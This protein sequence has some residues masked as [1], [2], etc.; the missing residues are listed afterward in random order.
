MRDEDVD[1]PSLDLPWWL[2]ILRKERYSVLFKKGTAPLGLNLFETRCKKGVYVSGFTPQQTPGA[3]LGQGLAQPPQPVTPPLNVIS[4]G[5]VLVSI[6][7][8]DCSQLSLSAV[9][10]LI[11]SSRRRDRFKELLTSASSKDTSGLA[12]K[13]ERK[14]VTFGF[15]RLRTVYSLADVVLDPRKL[16]FLVNFLEE[17]E[18]I[19]SR[20]RSLS[21]DN[22]VP[23]AGIASTL[24]SSTRRISD[25]FG[26]AFRG[27]NTPSPLRP[28]IA[29]S[30]H[31]LPPAPPPPWQSADGTAPIVVA[32]SV[33]YRGS[34]RSSGASS[35]V[36]RDEAK[37]RF[38]LDAQRIQDLMSTSALHEPEPD[39]GTAF[40]KYFRK[41]SAYDITSELD[42]DTETVVSNVLEEAENVACATG[43]GGGG[44]AVSESKWNMVE[45]VV[46]AVERDLIT[47]AF[48]QFQASPW[49]GR[50]VANLYGSASHVSVPLS[51]MLSKAPLRDTLMLF[52]LHEGSGDQR[53]L[54][55]WYEIELAVRPSLSA[56]NMEEGNDIARLRLLAAVAYLWDF[57]LSPGAHFPLHLRVGQGNAVQILSDILAGDGGLSDISIEVAAELGRA[58]SAAQVPVARHLASTLLPQFQSSAIGERLS[59]ELLSAGGASKMGS[60]ASPD[61]FEELWQAS[62]GPEVLVRLMRG[63]ERPQHISRHS[64]PLTQ[65]PSMGGSGAINCVDSEQQDLLRHYLS[66]PREHRRYGRHKVPESLPPAAKG[67]DWLIQFEGSVSAAG[68]VSCS[69]VHQVPLS[70]D[71]QRAPRGLPGSIGRFLCPDLP[72]GGLDGPCFY[73]ESPPPR[74]FSFAMPGS[75]GTETL[76]GACLLIHRPYRCST[77]NE[78]ETDEWA[79]E[80]TDN[81]Y[82]HIVKDTSPHKRLNTD[83][84]TNG[85]SD[86]QNININTLVHSRSPS[87]TPT[88]SVA[89]AA[90]LAAREDQAWPTSP[91]TYSLYVDVDNN[92][93]NSNVHSS[94]IGALGS[95]DGVSDPPL[96]AP[97][98]QVTERS[99]TPRFLP[100][101]I[102]VLSTSPSLPE[103]REGL[104]RYYSQISAQVMEQKPLTKGVFD[105]FWKGLEASDLCLAIVPHIT[106]SATKAEAEGRRGGAQPTDADISLLLRCLH[107]RHL[108]LLVASLLCEHKVIMLSDCLSLLTLAGEALRQLLRPLVW[109]HVYVPLLPH[110]M[111]RDL[112]QCPTPFLLGLPKPYA[113]GMDLPRE[114][115]RVD[116]DASHIWAPEGLLTLAPLRATYSALI[117]AL[118]PAVPVM[119]DPTPLPLDSIRGGA[120]EVLRIFR[121][122]IESLVA[123]SGECC[124]VVGAGKHRVALFDELAFFQVKARAAEEALKA[125][126]QARAQ[127]GIGAALEAGNAAGGGLYR[128][129]PA[130]CNNFTKTQMH[131]NYL[132]TAAVLRAA[133]AER[134][135]E[136]ANT[137]KSIP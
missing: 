26:T 34:V 105:Y 17:K 22:F 20:E 7:G 80:N 89:A 28:N 90:A 70:L 69:I 112:L 9:L 18:R 119:D 102:C 96:M 46:Q 104:S 93:Y 67:A 49:H 84:S 37:V 64:P 15:I 50:M 79:D 65:S 107:P 2:P 54:Q 30:L 19:R 115:V 36:S 95:G 48:P 101:G 78:T 68:A 113:A 3:P 133:V 44:K 4:V 24:S 92:M 42:P 77:D 131:S 87:P 5:D 110:C 83:T 66:L 59:A 16:A 53:W 32:P 43:C 129:D 8:Q 72:T 98:V 137:R 116:L 91:H 99:A 124:A 111:A 71:A 126:A 14:E 109:S 62:G 39:W 27:I 57:Y 38:W 73:H 125:E 132:A 12:S 127:T 52:L 13:A 123:G 81:F 23:S 21:P 130:F 82:T 114:A 29:S 47:N 128:H 51:A 63:A 100:C 31:S 45:P 86:T 40:L 134:V 88:L 135:A 61:Y 56:M 58:V 75:D 10:Q 1:E 33:G 85:T 6:D 108:C 120:E 121:V 103:L 118:A 122:T 41:G 97:R 55:A 25:E 60:T 74:L 11:E 106:E 35:R 94:G 117:S 76:Y 136:C